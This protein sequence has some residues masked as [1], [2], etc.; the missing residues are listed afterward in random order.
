MQNAKRRNPGRLVSR[1]L[2]P[3]TAPRLLAG[4]LAAAA[5][6]AVA[7]C[8]AFG[9]TTVANAAYANEPGA[10]AVDGSVSLSGSATGNAAQVADGKAGGYQFLTLNDRHDTTFNQLLGVNNEGVIAG[11]FGSG[12]AGHPNK[13]YQLKPPFAD[14]G[15]ENF[16]GSAQTQVTGLN[17]FGV[18]VGFFSTQNG[19]T[20]AN[21][22]NFG[23]WSHDGHFH[24]VDFPTWNHSNPPV[25]QLLGV[26]DSDIA[27]GFY[28][29]GKGNAHGYA[30]SLNQGWFRAVTIDGATS[31]TAAAI[32]NFDTVAG[33]Y[34]NAAGSTDGFVKFRNGHVVTLAV[35]G[36]SMTQATGLN[37][38]DEVVGTYTVGTGNNA[39]THGFTWQDGKY[40]TVNYPR[41]SSTSVNGVN[42]QGDVAGFYTDAAGNTDGFLGLP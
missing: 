10:G 11:Y 29:D 27:V 22:N 25:N 37:D 6:L 20:P 17:D 42:D 23:F 33:F 4:A 24:Q 39:V 19:A 9:S 34:T 1:R 41:A 21:D 8:S 12:N 32:N 35:P 16:P 31:L 5:A 7:G 3:R 30:Y 18:T 15:N 14:F 40:T 2:R 26:N 28:N 36:A 13:G 38:H